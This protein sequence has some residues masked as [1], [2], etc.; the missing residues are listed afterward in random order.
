ML[1]KAM[2]KHAASR[3]PLREWMQKTELAEWH[4]IVDARQTFK[5]TDFITG[6]DRTCFNIG[7]NN[8]RLITIV[9]YQLQV[10]SICE[11][12]THEEYTKKYVRRKPT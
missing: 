9:S 3:N 8:F 11:F 10:V 12:L 5:S 1:G 6:S 4:D 7:G 2:K